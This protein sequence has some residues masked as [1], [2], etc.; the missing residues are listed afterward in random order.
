M[1]AF[2]GSVTGE[3][4]AGERAWCD[5]MGDVRGGASSLSSY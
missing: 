5:S 2:A 1:E 3:R 4:V